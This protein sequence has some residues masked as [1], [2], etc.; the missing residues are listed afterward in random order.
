MRRECKRFLPDTSLNPP[1][2]STFHHK[3]DLNLSLIFEAVS[4]VHGQDGDTTA[5]HE[6]EVQRFD[7]DDE[8]FNLSHFFEIQVQEEPE[9]V[10]DLG[11]LSNPQVQGEPDDPQGQYLGMH[12]QEAD[13]S[14]QRPVSDDTEAFN[15]SLIFEVDSKELGHRGLQQSG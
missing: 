12:E 2:V 14:A 4:Q 15:S 6:T 7:C 11:M 8:A 9:D 10:Q 13:T 3:E 5:E 1:T